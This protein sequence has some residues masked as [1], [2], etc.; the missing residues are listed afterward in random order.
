[1]KF[2]SCTN[3]YVKSTNVWCYC[4]FRPNLFCG[5]FKKHF[6]R[7]AH[8]REGAQTKILRAQTCTNEAQTIKP[9]PTPLARVGGQHFLRPAHRREGAQTKILRAQTCTNEA[10]TIKPTPTPLARMGG[11]HF[12]RPPVTYIYFRGKGVCTNENIACTNVH[13][14]STND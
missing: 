12:L 8:R 13:K 6:L 4:F 2:N 11:H 5:V 7:P 3:L 10:Q 9:T 1:M 14:R